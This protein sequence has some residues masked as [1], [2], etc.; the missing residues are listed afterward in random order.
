MLC[1]S[2][3]ICIFKAK[4]SFIEYTF[5]LIIFFSLS[6]S[7]WLFWLRIVFGRIILFCSHSRLYFCFSAFLS[8]L[9]TLCRFQFHSDRSFA[10]FMASVSFWRISH[11]RS[12]AKKKREKKSNSIFFNFYS[13][14]VAPIF[15]RF[16]L[17]FV[18]LLLLLLFSQYELK[19][20]R[21]TITQ[22]YSKINTERWSLMLLPSSSTYRKKHLVHMN[23]CSVLGYIA[24]FRA[25]SETRTN[26]QT[27]KTETYT[28][29]QHLEYCEF[30][31][32]VGR[33]L[34]P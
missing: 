4:A 19:K 8:A 5:N 12:L 27:I 9:Y 14:C 1:F 7:C 18:N 29:Q 25:A 20:L 34:I 30:G 31:L 3:F 24:K 23:S 22:E 2:Q 16:S 11:T 26:S 21:D 17:R 10:I 28:Q 6:L 33:S 32:R 15:H 13:F